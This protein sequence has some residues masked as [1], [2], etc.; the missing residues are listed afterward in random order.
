VRNGAVEVV[1]EDVAFVGGH[2]VGG[3]DDLAVF[4]GID[5]DGRGRRGGEEGEECGG[6]HFC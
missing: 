4:A 6:L 5:A 2:A 1:L 3:E